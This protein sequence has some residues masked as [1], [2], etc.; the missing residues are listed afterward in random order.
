M[1][2]SRRTIE[3]LR[4]VGW[5]LVIAGLCVYLFYFSANYFVEREIEA[6]TG[7]PATATPADHCTQ[8]RDPKSPDQQHHF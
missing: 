1:K 2:T 5:S 7:M 8:C 3:L 6:V 4:T